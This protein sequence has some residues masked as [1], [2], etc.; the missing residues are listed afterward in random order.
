MGERETVWSTPL[1]RV[2]SRTKKNLVFTNIV[3]KFF[4]IEFQ[5]RV[6]VFAFFGIFEVLSLFSIFFLS[7][8]FLMFEF[9]SF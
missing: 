2:I 1:Y 3:V 9:L 5:N 6:G 8:F 7:L 4:K